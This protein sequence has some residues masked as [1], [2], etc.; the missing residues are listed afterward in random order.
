MSDLIQ[1]I[2]V[3]ETDFDKFLESA[4]ATTVFLAIVHRDHPTAASFTR[5]LAPFTSIGLM[6]IN[7]NAK[8]ARPV[9]DEMVT[10]KKQ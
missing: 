5:K 9:W 3:Y 7:F 4:K 10:R 2:E 8:P 6:D 1:T